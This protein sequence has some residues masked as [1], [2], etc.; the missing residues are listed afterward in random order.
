M[1]IALIILCP[2]AAALAALLPSNRRRPW[3]LPPVAIAHLGLVLAILAGY[4]GGAR[5]GWLEI[6]PP[7]RVVL[8]LV[9]VL[10]LLCSFY[11]AGY[12]CSRADHANRVFCSCFLLFLGAMTLVICTD[13]LGLMWVAMEATTL[14]SAPL[15]YFNRTPQSIEATWKYLLICSVGIALALLGSFFVAYSAVRRG[16]TP[17]LKIIDLLRQA[18]RLNKVWLQAGFVLLLVGYGTKMGLAPMHSWLPDAHGESPAPVSAMFSGALISSAF[19]MVVRSE[20]ILY[21]AGDGAYA[22]R[23]LI[24]LGLLSMLFAAIF[25]IGQKDLKRMLAYSSVEHM[26]ILAL[27]LG[28]GGIALL[29]AMLHVINNGLTKGSLFLSVGN[30]DRAYGGKTIPQVH[31]AMR[32]LPLSGTVFMLGFLAITGSPPFGPFISEFMILNGAFA[33]GHFLIGAA[34]LFLLLVIFLGMG[35]TVLAAVLGRAP[36]A[37]ARNNYRDGLLSGLPALGALLMVLLLGLYLP[38]PL[39]DLLHQAS[40]Y[41]GAKP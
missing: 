15:I 33:A 27:G 23:L 20:H 12:L 6:D 24:F 28:I 29:G 9:S 7:G 34:F 37:A 10:F 35:R 5:G 25:M 14:S 41:L 21:A 2:L 32:R 26:G 3:L 19:L 1:Y 13:N 8:L 22:S 18:P 30:I 16:M 4:G 36:V 31:G 39:R 40:R 38:P 17:S 11:L